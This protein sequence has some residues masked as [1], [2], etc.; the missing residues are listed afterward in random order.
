MKIALLFGGIFLSAL[1]YGQIVESKSIQTSQKTP[2]QNQAAQQV[3]ETDPNGIYIEL[4]LDPQNTTDAELKEALKA[5][6]YSNPE[7][8]IEINRKYLN[9]QGKQKGAT[10]SRA[11]FEALPDEKKQVILNN[12]ERYTI[13]D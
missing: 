12:P 4:G 5:L 7:K 6:H 9:P 3:Q 2:V 11:D 1:S 13:L 8:Y 10:I